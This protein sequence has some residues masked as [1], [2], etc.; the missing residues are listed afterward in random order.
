MELCVETHVNE[1]DC[2]ADVAA[3]ITLYR[4]I[5]ARLQTAFEAANEVSAPG[6]GIVRHWNV[7]RPNSSEPD[8]QTRYAALLMCCERCIRGDATE[9]SFAK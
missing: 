6:R 7:E 8:P 5:G 2:Q 1:R 3:Y 4:E 9:M